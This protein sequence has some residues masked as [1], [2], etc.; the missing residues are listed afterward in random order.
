MSAFRDQAAKG[1]ASRSVS[2]VGACDEQRNLR[3][4]WASGRASWRAIKAIT[5]YQ[6]ISSDVVVDIGCGAGRLTRAIAP[7]VRHVYGFD[8]SQEMLELAA[9]ADIPNATYYIPHGFTLRQLPDAFVDCVLAYSVFQNLPSLDALRIYLSDMVR[10]AKPGAFIAFTLPER[11]RTYYLQPL[12]RLGE[13]LL[14][15]GE[16]GVYCKERSGIRPAERQV[17]RLCPVPL[18]RVKL[19]GNQ[20]LWFGFAPS[21]PWEP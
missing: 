15:R 21:L 1:S 20:W 6:P 8:I 18:R 10:V 12:R 17:R 7:Q 13:R 16:V 4:F 14:H 11:D 19:H 2:S 5:G 3:E 9:A